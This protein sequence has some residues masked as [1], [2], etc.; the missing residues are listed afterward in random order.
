[1]EWNLLPQKGSG[2]PVFRLRGRE[3]VSLQDKELIL[4][5]STVPQLLRGARRGLRM[6]T[7]MI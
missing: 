5:V 2:K 3:D 6:V 7:M 4:A 1:M